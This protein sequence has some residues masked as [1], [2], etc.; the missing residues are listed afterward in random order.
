[1]HHLPTRTHQ[2]E[3]VPGPENP[4]AGD[5]GAPVVGHEAGTSSAVPSST[6]PRPSTA[7]RMDS[8][9]SQGRSWPKTA[10]PATK[11]FAPALAA[12]GAV[13]TSI[14]PSTSTSIAKEPGVDGA[15]YLLDLAHDIGDEALATEAGEHGHAQHEI[16]ASE[17]RLH[18]IERC[19]GVEREAGAQIEAAHLGHEIGR[20]ADLDVHRAAVRTRVG[21]RLEVAPGLGHHEVTVEEQRRVAPQRRDD[22]RADGDVRHEMPVHHVDVEPVSGRGHLADLFGQHPE[23]RGEE[24]GGD[25]KQPGGTGLACVV[26][27]RR[28]GHGRG[29][30]QRKR[31]QHKIRR[32]P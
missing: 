15:A 27:A 32:N 19:V 30:A 17:V 1:M 16:D 9:V 2:L 28:L 13:S 26:R 3:R 31:A 12:T 22:R 24:R 20:A 4:A 29:L 25:T 8:A 5:D 23:I 18:R 11:T 21:E 7:A 14:P 6:P 10:L